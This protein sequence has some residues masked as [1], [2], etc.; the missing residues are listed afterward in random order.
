MHMDATNAVDPTTSPTQHMQILFGKDRSL[1]GRT[2]VSI[3]LHRRQCVAPHTSHV[4]DCALGASRHSRP[5][6]VGVLHTAPCADREGGL[7]RA[8]LPGCMTSTNRSPHATRTPHGPPWLQDQHRRMCRRAR[9]PGGL[10]VMEVI[11]DDGSSFTSSISNG[12]SSGSYD[13]R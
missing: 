6:L 11:R 3:G 1:G 8:R 13:H 5:Y 2:G 10:V 4:T 7:P 12:D 9:V